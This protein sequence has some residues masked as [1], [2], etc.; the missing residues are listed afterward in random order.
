MQDA[1]EH[2]DLTPCAIMLVYVPTAFCQGGLASSCPEN[3]VA[4]P[5]S[6]DVLDCRCKL[7]YFSIYEA[8]ND[9]I[10]Q[11]CLVNHYCPGGPRGVSCPSNSHAAAGS[12]SLSACECND[13]YFGSLGDGP[14]QTS[15]CYLCE[16]GTWCSGGVQVI[17]MHS[18]LVFY[19]C[20]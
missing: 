6:D 19:R 15:M 8:P 10:C 16:P 9:N 5:G 1:V 3:S 14:G 4:P 7:G 17:S 11:T 12:A 13:G 2:N 20:S 18:T